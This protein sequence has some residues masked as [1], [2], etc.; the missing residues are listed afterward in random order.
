[1]TDK[2]ISIIALTGFAL[3]LGI[4]A[5]WVRHIDLVIVLALGFVFC[6]YDFYRASWAKRD[7]D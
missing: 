7:G 6:A 3:F 5:Y 2:I 1:M 4:L